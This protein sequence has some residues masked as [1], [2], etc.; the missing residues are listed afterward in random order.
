VAKIGADKV[1]WL[2][3]FHEP[4]R[5]TIEDLQGIKAHYRALVRQMK[6]DAA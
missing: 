2:E 5:Y 3:G 4:M 6:R 1:T